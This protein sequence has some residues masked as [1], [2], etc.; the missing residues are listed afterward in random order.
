MSGLNFMRA[1][2]ALCYY[3]SLPSTVTDYLFSVEFLE[4][5]DEELN[6]CYAKVIKN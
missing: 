3:Y 2:L 5:L 1:C 4:R 6:H